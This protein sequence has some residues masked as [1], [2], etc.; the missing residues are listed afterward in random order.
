MQ[1]RRCVC[2]FLPNDDTLNVIVNVKTLCQELLVQVCDLLRLKDRHLFGLSVIQNNEH[3]YME[4][5]QKLSK[6]CPKEWKREASKVTVLNPPS[7]SLS[8]EPSGLSRSPDLGARGPIHTAQY[9]EAREGP[10]TRQL[11]CRF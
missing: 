10:Y 8:L 6:Y 1:D 2:V 4:L 5:D 9:T 3:I 11:T 7:L